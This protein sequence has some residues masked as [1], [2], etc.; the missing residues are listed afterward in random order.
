MWSDTLITGTYR[1]SVIHL[2]NVCSN[3]QDIYRLT[4]FSVSKFCLQCFHWFPSVRGKSYFGDYAYGYIHFSCI[5]AVS[6]VKVTCRGGSL[7]HT[8]GS[9]SGVSDTL[10]S[11]TL[12]PLLDPWTSWGTCNVCTAGMLESPCTPAWTDP[13]ACMFLSDGYSMVCDVFTISRNSRDI[14]DGESRETMDEER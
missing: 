11:N 5:S 12:C 6:S 1:R 14:S 13:R 7:G 10:S 9:F 8:G 3:P 4:E 2:S